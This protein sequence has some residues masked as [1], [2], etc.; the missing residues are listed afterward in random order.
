[1]NDFGLGESERVPAW[2]RL[3][4]RN[5]ANLLELPVL[6]YLVCLALFLTDRA[7]P[8]QLEL[9]WTYVGLRALHIYVTFNYV[10]LRLVA[11]AAS[12]TVLSMMWM[13][14]ARS[15]LSAGV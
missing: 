11:F 5:L 15:L 10:P 6:F 2:V 12:L 8:L 1:M 13:R 9:A 3:S 4:S 7:S 14:F